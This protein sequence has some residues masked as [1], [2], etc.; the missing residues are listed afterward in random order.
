MHAAFFFVIKFF[1]LTMFQNG[2]KGCGHLWRR[3]IIRTAVGLSL[4]IREFFRRAMWACACLFVLRVCSRCGIIGALGI[5]H[6]FLLS[7][8]QRFIDGHVCA[9]LLACAACC[10]RLGALGMLY[11]FILAHQADFDVKWCRGTTGE[12][13]FKPW[14]ERIQQNGA[15]VL[16]ERRA[17]KNGTAESS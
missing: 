12:M 17:V 4:L 11:F 9:C 6:V 13:I 7:L 1:L 10:C 2:Q 8:L 3:R 14:V 15:K 16:V 5:S